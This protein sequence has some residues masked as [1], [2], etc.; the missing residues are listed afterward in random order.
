MLSHLNFKP[1]EVDS[2]VLAWK[3]SDLPSNFEL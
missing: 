3:I 2:I 1:K